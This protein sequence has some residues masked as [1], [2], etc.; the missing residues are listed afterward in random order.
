MQIGEPQISSSL[1]RLVRHV[2]ARTAEKWCRYTLTGAAS[3]IPEI[4]LRNLSLPLHCRDSRIWVARPDPAK[5][6]ILK[7]KLEGGL[8]EASKTSWTKFSSLFGRRIPELQ[9]VYAFYSVFPASDKCVEG[10]RGKDRN[11]SDEKDSGR[12]TG[13]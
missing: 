3:Q 1:F 6:R 4:Y 9:P 8:K 7:L 5:T 12:L 11:V 10:V 2:R 13:H